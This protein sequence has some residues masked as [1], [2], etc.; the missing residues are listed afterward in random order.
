MFRSSPAY[1][2]HD[3]YS[4]EDLKDAAELVELCLKWIPE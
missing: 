4:D 3:I 2:K 1:L